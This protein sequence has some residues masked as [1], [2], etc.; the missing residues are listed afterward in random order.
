M[1]AANQEK[2]YSQFFTDAIAMGCVW[3]LEN[4]D[5][6]AQCES[7]KHKQT[8]VM[9]FW[10]QP[11]YAQVHQKNEWLAYKVMAISL[12][13]FLDDWLIGMHKDAILTGI[14]WNEQLDG[15]EYEPL[16]ILSEFEHVLKER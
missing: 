7:E 12:E 3:S 5:G 14:N 10:S 8:L 16:D 1:L 6:W 9:P 4:S 15:E 13:E 2:N 11:E